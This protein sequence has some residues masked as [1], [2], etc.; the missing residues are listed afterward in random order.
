MRI[1]IQPMSLRSHSVRYATERISTTVRITV[2]TVECTYGGRASQAA[3][4]SFTRRP[5][6]VG[7]RVDGRRSAAIHRAM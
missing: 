1:C 2:N 6:R 7:S 5:S 3:I 4:A